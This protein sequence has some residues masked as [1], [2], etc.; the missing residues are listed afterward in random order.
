METVFKGFILRP[1][2][3]CLPGQIFVLLPAI[4]SSLSDSCRAFSVTCLAPMATPGITKDMPLRKLR[5]LMRP[6]FLGLIHKL[7]YLKIAV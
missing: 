7:F 6:P 4:I 2:P 3:Q 5:W 1:S